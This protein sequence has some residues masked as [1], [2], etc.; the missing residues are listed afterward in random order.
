VIVG[1]YGRLSGQPAG[2]AEFARRF[3]A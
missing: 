1:M 2:N 3:G